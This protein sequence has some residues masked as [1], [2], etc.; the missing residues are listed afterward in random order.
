METF[1]SGSDHPTRHPF[2]SYYVVWKRLKDTSIVV[3]IFSLNRTMQYGNG[4]AQKYDLYV[5]LC[6]NR[7]MQY[8]NLFSIHLPTADIQFKS[9]YVVWKLEWLTRQT[10]KKRKFK[11]YYVVWKPDRQ[12]K[13]SLERTEFK[14]YYVVWKLHQKPNDSFPPFC[15]NRTMQYGNAVVGLC[16]LKPH[17][18]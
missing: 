12:K 2:K 1:S 16:I 5:V 8:G 14:S 7:T 10:Q 17:P 13:H 9:Y 18:V 6:L 11:S 4:L 3:S 15:L